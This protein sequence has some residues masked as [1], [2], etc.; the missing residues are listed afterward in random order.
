MSNMKLTIITPCSRPENLQKIKESINVKC[1]WIICYDSDKEIKNFD[2]DWIIE[3][4]TK[5]GIAG[6]KQ[7][8]HALDYVDKDSWVYVLDDDNLLHHKFNI[9]LFS[10]LSFYYNGFIFSQELPDGSIRIPSKDNIKV[11][12]VDQAQ[13][14]LHMSLIGEKRFIQQYEADGIFIEQIYNEHADKILVTSEVL[15]YYNK[16]RQ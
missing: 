11:C 4:F 14:L 1:T 10:R 12:H 9:D 3:I 16:L 13:Y 7:V 8:N 2:D 6:K 5:G 15:C